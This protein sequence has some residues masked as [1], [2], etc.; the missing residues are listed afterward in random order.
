MT[1]RL[2]INW[3][4]EEEKLLSF[5]LSQYGK[6]NWYKIIS[7]FHNN[8]SLSGCKDNYGKYG[9][10]TPYLFKLPLVTI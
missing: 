1:T 8:S 9:G 3:S 6:K 4:P 7:N 10:M 2:R 5:S